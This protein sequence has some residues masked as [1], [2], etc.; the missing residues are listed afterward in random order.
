MIDLGFA[1]AL[2]TN[3]GRPE[4]LAHMVDCR[5]CKARKRTRRA[6]RNQR[7]RADAL[8]S[9]GMVKTPYGWE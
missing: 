4:A 3:E 2:T 9:L 8:R 5:I 7:E 1:S 6:N